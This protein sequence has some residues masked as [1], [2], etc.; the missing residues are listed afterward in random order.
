M[1]T[2][3]NQETE[4]RRRILLAA[5]PLFVEHGYKSVSMQQ[6]ADAVPINK[7]T[8][9]HHFRNKDALF[10]DVVSL[11]SQ[12]LREQIEATIA[13]G[14]SA[15]EQL[16]QIAVQMFDTTQSDLGRL[17]TD[18]HEHLPMDDRLAL[19]RDNSHPWDLYEEIFE[20]AM[21]AGE[22]PASDA[23]LSTSMF[24][25]L[26]HGQIWSRKIGK[27]DAPLDAELG[28]LIVRTLFT[29]LTSVEPVGASR[30][31]RLSQPFVS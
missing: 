30:T 19:M 28:R 23:R 20:S 9:Y 4:G 31:G 5:Y 24:I 8:L 10:L 27:L 26:V 21:M 16:A 7:A 3:R 15:E 11:A 22:I 1:D 14:G 6:I 17:M 12:R 25:G 29:G 2:T 18:A 13:A